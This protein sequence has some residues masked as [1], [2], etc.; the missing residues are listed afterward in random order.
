MDLYFDFCENATRGSI[1]GQVRMRLTPE[2]G[3]ELDKRVAKLDVPKRHHANLAAILET[4]DGLAVSEEVRS[5]MRAIYRILTEAEATVHETTVEA[6]HFHEVGRAAGIRNVAEICLAIEAV[7]PERIFSTPVQ[8]GLGTVECAHGTLA[9]PAPATAVILD[10]GVPTCVERLKGERCTP[11]S[12]AVIKHYVDEFVGEAAKV[13]Y[14][15]GPVPEQGR[16]E[17]GGAHEGYEGAQVSG[18][19]Y[20]QTHAQ[21]HTHTHAQAHAYAHV[22]EVPA[23]AKSWEP[24]V[25]SDEQHAKL[26]RLREIL[27]DL[28]NVAVAF[29]GGVDST[30]LLAVAH[31]ALGEHAFAVTETSALN[32]DRETK[33][34]EQFCTERGIRQAKVERDVFEVEGLAKNGQDRCYVCKRDLLEK[35]FDAAERVAEETGVLDRSGG[36]IHLVEGSN[37]TD[38]DDYRPGARAVREFGARSPLDEADLTKQ[39]IRD[40]SREKGLSTWNKPSF[41]CLASR[42]ATDQSLT[43]E[44]LKTIEEAENLMMDEGFAQVR[45]RV[46]ENGTLARIEVAADE[47]ERA[48]HV[49]AHHGVREAMH[50]LGFV[51]VALDVDGYRTGNMNR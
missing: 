9:L 11:T 40:L 44:L 18:H 30:F 5:H 26:E 49:L 38:R 33:F 8:A 2:A 45:V 23:S 16:A 25:A 42:V 19:E 15:Q 14:F 12:A 3:T 10:S 47:V 29:S 50:D 31:E 6:A 27:R 41:A 20:A 13:R 7:A 28:G 24:F 35:L 51:H 48:L 32:P 34:A 46:H 22:H 37:A 21:A 1:L 36:P 43:P 39:D 4:I 17:H